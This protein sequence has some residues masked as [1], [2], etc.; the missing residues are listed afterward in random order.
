MVEREDGPKRWMLGYIWNELG[1][2]MRSE[3]IQGS[4]GSDE[5]VESARAWESV[6]GMETCT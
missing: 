1:K 4:V 3:K 6:K 5:T 2:S